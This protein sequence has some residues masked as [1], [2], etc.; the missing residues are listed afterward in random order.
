MPNTDIRSGRRRRAFNADTFNAGST[1]QLLS[2]DV[3]RVLIVISPSSGVIT[4]GPDSSTD[5]NGPLRI[6]AAGQTP[7]ILDVENYGG[8][9]TGPIWG[10]FNNG[11]TI[12]ILVVQD[13]EYNSQTDGDTPIGRPY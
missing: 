9:V 3:T 12:P 10:R 8:M 7:L 11:G 1:A 6:P 5:A 4:I 2:F 13:T